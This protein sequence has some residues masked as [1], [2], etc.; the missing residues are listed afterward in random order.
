MGALVRADMTAALTC[1]NGRV[2]S[3]IDRITNAAAIDAV[4]RRYLYLRARN[5]VCYGDFVRFNVDTTCTTV[6]VN[7]VCSC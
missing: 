4:A 3:D 1:F 2:T 7:Q 5:K 6:Q